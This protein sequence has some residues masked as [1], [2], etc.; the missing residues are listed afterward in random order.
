MRN[1]C[2]MAVQTGKEYSEHEVNTERFST[3]STGMNHVE[4]G[5]PKDVNPEEA[6]QTARYR[7]KAEKKES[8]QRS[9]PNLGEVRDCTWVY[10]ER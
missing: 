2:E 4:G 9:I 7:K 8:F 5:W 3:T 1:P 6:E 10:T